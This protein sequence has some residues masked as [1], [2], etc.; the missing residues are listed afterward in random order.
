[1]ML[2]MTVF[3]LRYRRFM[4]LVGIAL[5]AGFQRYWEAVLLWGEGAGGVGGVGAGR[6]L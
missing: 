6:V 4:T 1:M 2:R 5:F 3:F